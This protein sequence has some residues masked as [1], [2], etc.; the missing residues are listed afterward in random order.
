MPTDQLS[1]KNHQLIAWHG[2]RFVVP[3]AWNPVKVDGDYDQGVMLL[4][5]MHNAKL[6]IRWR[7][8]K[9][10]DPAKIADT[11]LLAEVGKLATSEATDFAMPDPTAWKLSRLYTEPEPPGRDIWVGHSTITG[12]MIEIVHHVKTRTNDLIATVLP[13][14]T[15]TPADQSQAWAIFDLSCKSPAGWALQWFRLNAGDL[16][17]AFHK[18]RQSVRARQVGPASL[19]LSRMKLDK[20]IGQL[21]KAHSKIYQEIDD[22]SDTTLEIPSRTLNGRA[23]KLHRKKRLFWAITFAKEMKAIG[24]HD[25]VR[26]RLILAAG[27]DESVMRQMLQ[28]MGWTKSL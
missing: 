7:T 1:T 22:L 17:L 4:A 20:W 27:D 28:T 6:G 2:W 13:S 9:R 24:F 18:K 11:L 19:A 15:D 23:G 21:D 16:T 12:R 3:D 26:N 10:G 8:Q 25:E 14:V 5:D